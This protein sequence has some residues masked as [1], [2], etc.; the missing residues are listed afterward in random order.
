V[1][2]KTLPPFAVI[3]TPKQKRAAVYINEDKIL[4]N[5]APLPEK[6]FLIA[7]FVLSGKKSAENT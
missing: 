7:T 2:Y 1:K 5:A 6:F 3:I 4:R